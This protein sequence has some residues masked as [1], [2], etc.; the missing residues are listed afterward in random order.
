MFAK[1]YS[2]IPPKI[3]TI[4]LYIIISELVL[5][6]DDHIRSASHAYAIHT[7]YLRTT[8]QQEHI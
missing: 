1:N 6:M 8:P 4:K 7:L 5:N 2:H 3:F